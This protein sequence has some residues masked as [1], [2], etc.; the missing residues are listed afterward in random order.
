MATALSTTLYSDYLKERWLESGALQ[1]LLQHKAPLIGLLKTDETAGGRHYHTPI[2]KKRP[3]GRSKVY[4]TAVANATASNVDAFDVT[5]VNDYQQGILERNV[6]KQS[7]GDKNAIMTALDHEMKGAIVNLKKNLRRGFYNNTGGARGFVSA[8]STVTLTLT[9]V[10]DMVNFEVG[11]HVCCSATDGTSGA[12]RDSGTYITVIGVNY[13][14][15]TLTGDAS[16]TDLASIA[17]G[18]G[19]FIEGDFGIDFAG[20]TGWVPQA[21]PGATAWYGVARNTH[22]VLGGLRYDGRGKPKEDAIKLA[23][24]QA[25]QFDANLDLGVCCPTVWADMQVG[26]SADRGNRLTSVTDKKAITGYEAIMV[27]TAQ[28]LM[29]MVSDPSCPKD[30]IFLLDKSTWTIASV[31]GPLVQIADEDG[32]LIRRGSAD[33]YTFDAITLANL[34]CNAPGCNVNVRIAD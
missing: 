10:E 31:D 33:D 16:W 14:A 22:S 24:G 9:N 30:T 12:L 20:L 18:D 34:C 5:Y 3:G 6:I 7:K 13:E 2:L 11:D 15:A 19:L 21:A 8:E 17:A 23:S 28:G 1:Q 27:A 32:L 26:L 29:P 4:A 25:E